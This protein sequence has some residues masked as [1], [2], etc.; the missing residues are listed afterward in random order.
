MYVLKYVHSYRLTFVV[1]EVPNLLG[2]GIFQ[3][4]TVIIT[5][6]YL[7]KGCLQKRQNEDF[8]F[9]CFDIIWDERTFLY[10]SKRNLKLELFLY[11]LAVETA[12]CEVT[13]K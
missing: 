8:C 13:E 11:C 12:E 1:N 9:V 4:D 3:Q 2:K 6:N 10:K 5:L 7:T